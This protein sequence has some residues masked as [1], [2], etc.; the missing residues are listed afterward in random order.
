[1]RKIISSPQEACDIRCNV[2][3]HIFFLISFLEPLCWS[4]LLDAQHIS[5][6]MSSSCSIAFRS[7]WLNT[8]S[9]MVRVSHSNPN[10]FGV[11]GELNIHMSKV[12]KSKCFYSMYHSSLHCKG[13]G[14]FVGSRF[15]CGVTGEIWFCDD[16]IYYFALTAFL[17]HSQVSDSFADNDRAQ[18][19]E[20]WHSLCWCDTMH[21]CPS[22]LSVRY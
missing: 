18:G 20:A 5:L 4:I 6:M 9:S 7:S 1:M 12:L 19:R 21:S 22:D 14:S 3:L 8:W 15:I 10:Q 17:W 11:D 16:I 13:E 2:D